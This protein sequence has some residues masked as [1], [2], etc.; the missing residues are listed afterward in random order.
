MRRARLL[1][2]LLALLAAGCGR[3]KQG[4][5]PI[6]IGAVLSITGGGAFLGDPMLKSL[7]LYVERINAQGGVNGRRLELIHYDDASD[8]AKANAFGRRLIESDRVDLIIGPTSTGPTLALIPL[9][10]RARVPLLSLAGAVSIVDPVRKWVFKTPTSDR[11]AVERV[12]QDLQ[13]RGL[14]RVALLVETGG[15]GQSGAREAET[16]AGKY[17]ITLVRREEYGQKDSD[18]TPQLTRLR[19]APGVQAVFVIGFGQGAVMATRNYHQLGIA[20]PLYHAHGVA[21]DE[22][23]RLSGAAAE[24]VRLPSPALLVADRLPADAP[25][26]AVVLDY[27]ASYRERYR[28]EPATFGGYAYDALMIAVEAL[29]KAGTDREK[30]RDAIEQTHGWV[31]TQGA[32]NMSPT[33]HIGLT[34]EA[35][36]IVEIRNGDWV[37]V[38]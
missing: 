32:V 28:Q 5:E 14:R 1:A 3:E 31:G 38:D 26:R 36:R 18:V 21:S 2:I 4:Q 6:R 29:K 30:L 10:E 23:I 7:Q 12:F 34:I 17:G 24:G 22:F 13:R 16:V 35:L 20:L 15:F 8:A 11:M 27:I 37:P 25:E 19:S 33:D 9:V